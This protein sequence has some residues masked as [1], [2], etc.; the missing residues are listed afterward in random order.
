MRHHIP[1]P[2]GTFPDPN[3]CL[4]TGGA[5]DN[6][7]FVTDARHEPGPTSPP[8]D[9]DRLREE[10]ASAR[11]V[12]EGKEREFEQFVKAFRDAPPAARP[13]TSVRPVPTALVEPP[14]EAYRDRP[15]GHGVKTLGV[16][17]TAAV[18]MMA[19]AWWPAG[20]V[21]APN[22]P[23]VPAQG[24]PATGSP[25]ASAP[26]SETPAPATPAEPPA[27]LNVELTTVPGGHAP[28]FD[29]PEEMAQAIRA[30]LRNLS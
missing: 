25:V 8:E 29:R 14:R 5:G 12:R 10:L 19:W 1:G 2:G 23:E 22:F 18:L 9:L 26:A 27:A 30:D 21:E 24:P 13:S 7:V 15:S 28:Y 20:E 11:R 4:T 16:I 6:V 3:S 17:G